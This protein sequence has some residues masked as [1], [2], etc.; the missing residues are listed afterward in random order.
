MSDKSPFIVRK[1]DRTA[2][3][4]MAEGHAMNPNAWIRGHALSRAAG[5]KRVGV[6]AVTVPAGK[7]SFVYHRHHLEEEFMFVLSGRGVVEIDAGEHEIGAGDF[8]GFPPGTA[9]HV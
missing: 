6:W 8:V 4:E 3:N 9:H 1:A 2:E 7:E 5:L